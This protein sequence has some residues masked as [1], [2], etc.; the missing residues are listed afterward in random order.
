MRWFKRR[1]SVEISRN[2]NEIEPAILK[3]AL[4]EEI[5]G[6]KLQ[7]LLNAAEDQ[8]GVDELIGSLKRKQ[9]VF[10]GVLADE[11]ID[12]LSSDGVEILL[13]AVF[14][15]RRKLPDSLN[16]VPHEVLQQKV[17]HLLCGDQPI[18]NRM[19][20]FVA[21]VDNENRKVQRAAWDFSAELLHFNKPEQFP[22]MS[23]W[24]WNEKETSGS[25]REFIRGGDTM[26]GVTFGEAPSDFEASRVWFAKQLGQQGFYRDI[27]F[28]IDLLF[29]QAYAEYILS[30]SSGLGMFGSQF[31]SAEL[32]P[33]ELVVK[34][35][36]IEP[37][38]KND[39][40]RLKK[41]V[42]H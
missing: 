6:Q 31:G 23:R 39:A 2:H 41:A 19:Q 35:L 25:L 38:R 4:D 16:K 30:M 34:L 1:S 5:C 8:G 10:S 14:T 37:A 36:G 20:Q 28:L 21:L 11:K 18:I 9:Q 15:A 27:H 42:V 24:V 22:L 40:M 12:K 26:R 32:R 13:D 33:I 7:Q 29:A 17:K 3:I